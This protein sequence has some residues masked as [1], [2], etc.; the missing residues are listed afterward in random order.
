MMLHGVVSPQLGSLVGEQF[1]AGSGHAPV[2]LLPR[3]YQSPA[4]LD[5]AR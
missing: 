5:G 4:M 3:R 2:S 1:Y